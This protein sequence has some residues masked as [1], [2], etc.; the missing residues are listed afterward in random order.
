[1]DQETRVRMSAKQTS[2]GSIQLDLTAEAQDVAT[3]RTLLSDAI[4][5]AL[6]VIQEKG[7]IP[8]HRVA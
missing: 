5:E 6:K 8:A 4:D 3:A 1:M 7:L 2:K